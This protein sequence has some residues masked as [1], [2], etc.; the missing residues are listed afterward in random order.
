[1]WKKQRFWREKKF[2]KIAEK[3]QKKAILELWCQMILEYSKFS[4][5]CF[6]FVSDGGKSWYWMEKFKHEN[7]RTRTWWRGTRICLILNQQLISFQS[8]VSDF[9]F[10]HF[11]NYCKMFSEVMSTFINTCIVT[12][13]L[14]RVGQAHD[15][16]SVQKHVFSSI[17]KHA[18]VTDLI[19][20]TRTGFLY[21]FLY[22]EK[23][24]ESNK[25]CQSCTSLFFSLVPLRNIQKNVF[26]FCVH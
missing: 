24:Q 18:K 6:V 23:L 2:R 22:K 15:A 19:L 3:S 13:L 5:Y 9:M 21:E 20:E 16:D 25:V 26:E 8:V 1:M 14:I 7:Y 12:I 11:I 4:F 17:W 10:F